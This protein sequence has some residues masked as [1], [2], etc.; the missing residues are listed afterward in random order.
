MN[1]QIYQLKLDSLQA[2]HFIEKYGGYCINKKNNLYNIT[3]YASS[4]VIY[5][6]IATIK[7]AKNIID[8]INK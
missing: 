5:N 8:L 7:E 3:K 1:L 6:Y 4:Q 2:N